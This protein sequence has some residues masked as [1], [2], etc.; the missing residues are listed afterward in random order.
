MCDLEKVWFV[1]EEVT[2]ECS[3]EGS[4]VCTRDPALYHVIAHDLPLLGWLPY[5]ELAPWRVFL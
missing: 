4:H 2:S 1:V 3:C 5:P